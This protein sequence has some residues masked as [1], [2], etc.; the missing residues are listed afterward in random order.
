MGLVTDEEKAVALAYA[1]VIGKNPN[2]VNTELED[3]TKVTA[4]IFS[5]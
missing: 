4:A 2:L 5:E 1:A 3:F